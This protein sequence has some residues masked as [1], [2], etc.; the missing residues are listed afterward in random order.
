MQSFLVH[1]AACHTVLQV[2]KVKWLTCLTTALVAVVFSQPAYANM[3]QC[4]AGDV[5]CLI[6]AINQ[7]N[8]NG[9]K[10]TIRLE[11][12][13]YDLTFNNNTDGPNGLPSIAGDLTIEGARRGATILQRAPSSPLFRLLHVATSGNLT[14][15]KVNLTGSQNSN[16]DRGAALYNKGRVTIIGC[17]V[18]GYRGAYG[19]LYNGDGSLMSIIRSSVSDN[20][21]TDST[22][23]SRGAIEID[24]STFTRNISDSPPI[25]MMGGIVRITLSRFNENQGDHF[26]G[27]LFVE[28]G[29]AFVANSTFDKNGAD[30]AGAILV[31]AEGS[32]LVTDSVFT[33]NFAFGVGG[34]IGNGGNTLV[35]NTT[36]GRNV[37]SPPFGITLVIINS[38][39]LKLVNSTLA[40]YRVDPNTNAARN[41][42]FWSMTGA[43]TLLQNTVIASAN[44]V[45]GVL[46]F[47]GPITSLGN[48]LFGN[49][50]GCN[51]ALQPSDLTGDPRLGAFVDNGE[52]G[53]GHF[54][55]LANSPAIDAGNDDACSKRD[56]IGEQRRGI[57]DIGA[58]EFADKKLKKP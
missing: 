31:R 34:V 43:T 33:R 38:G 1:L 26:A 48:N 27:V 50:A 20:F 30:G 10:N 32:L 14:L 5:G 23:I 25:W 47:E 37:S 6:A 42:V 41:F 2:K 4:A 22:V 11:A 19:P 51:V 17:T 45:Q 18:S 40:E 12:G 55:L 54:P 7:A 35:I 57:C 52:P 28:S 24:R 8:A 58:V 15:D 39:T 9:R 53:N 21:S 46:C 36:F 16:D 13:T 29:T 56:Q 49:T 3:F 44:D